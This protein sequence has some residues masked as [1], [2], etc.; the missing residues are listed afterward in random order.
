MKKPPFLF[1]LAAAISVGGGFAAAHDPSDKS[2]AEASHGHE[3]PHESLT[4]AEFAA[5]AA[6]DG[7]TEVEL[8]R[9]ALNKSQDKDV[10]E[11]A[12]R[13]LKDHGKANSQ[14]MSIAQQKKLQVPAQ[15]DSKHRAMVDELKGKS[16]AAFD[17]A[18]SQHMA[19]DHDKVVDYFKHAA[20]SKGVD[21]ELSAFARDTLPTLKEHKRMADAL[22]SRKGG[23][24]SANTDRSTGNR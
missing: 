18:Y 10:Q 21:S 15:L 4:S 6:Q 22:Q 3:S 7:M 17:A 16:G 1:A 19:M 5:K 9:V 23:T 20:V 24:A 11:F 12:N 8:A 13:M 2:G 14:L